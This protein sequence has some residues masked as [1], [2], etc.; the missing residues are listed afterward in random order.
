MQCMPQEL[1]RGLV[2]W[3]LAAFIPQLLWHIQLPA[4]QHQADLALALRNVTFH[5]LF[6]CRGAD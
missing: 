4:H 6:G 5:G 1:D 2:A 3:E